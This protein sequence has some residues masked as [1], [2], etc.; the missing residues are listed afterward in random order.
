MRISQQAKQENRNKILKMAMELFSNKGFEDTTTR[1]VAQATGMATGTLFN[2]FPSKETLAMHMV[3]RALQ[4]GYEEYKQR[5]IGNENLSEELY[6]FIFSGLR[7][8]QPYHSFL[9]PVFERSLSPFPRKTLC[10]EGETTKQNHLH[11]VTHIINS[12]GFDMSEN[13][14]I[15]TMYWSVYLGILAF[16]VNDDSP[17]QQES[18]AFIDYALHFFVQAISGTELNL[19]VNNA[20]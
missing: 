7:K 20:K 5:K 2:Y 3:R 19:G 6:L 11:A 18:H 12:H 14:M 16:W 10:I 17:K 9:G 8:L 15:S 4:Q 13:T 1:D